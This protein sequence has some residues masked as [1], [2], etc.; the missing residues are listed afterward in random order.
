MPRPILLVAVAATLALAPTPTTAQQPTQ[1]PLPANGWRLDY[2]HSAVTFRVRHLG[3]S[4]VNGRFTSWQGALI[5]DPGNPTAASVSATIAT[6]SVN[7]ENERRDA[8]IRSGN[9]MAVDSFPQMSFVSTRV[10]KVDDT[11]LRVTGDLTIRGVTRQVILETEILGMLEGPRSRRVA[12]SAT[13]LINRSDFGVVF[14]RLMD[15]A[16]IVGEE[17]RI[18]I[19]IEANQPIG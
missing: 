6:S 14:N 7:T 1:P 4:W 10:A 9:Y 11:H 3:I 16:A 13:T 18:T 17:I 8:D 5:Y 12:F 15:G 2:T 19:D